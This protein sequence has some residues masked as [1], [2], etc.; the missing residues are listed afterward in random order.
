M[1]TFLLLNPLQQCRVE[2]GRVLNCRAIWYLNI[3][4]KLWLTLFFLCFCHWATP[5]T[6]K[7]RREE[8]KAP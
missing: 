7:V 3:V 8:S 1:N 2:S 6:M 4:I 5:T